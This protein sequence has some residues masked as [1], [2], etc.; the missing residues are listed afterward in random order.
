MLTNTLVQT[1]C[2]NRIFD[3]KEKNFGVD[4]RRF[5]VTLISGF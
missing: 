1:F 3:F 4:V 2:S 5:S